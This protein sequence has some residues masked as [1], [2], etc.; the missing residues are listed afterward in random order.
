ME[1]IENRN[2]HKSFAY[3]TGLWYNFTRVICMAFC[4][5]YTKNDKR[6]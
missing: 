2:L 4:N 3:T 5:M 6:R 1:Y